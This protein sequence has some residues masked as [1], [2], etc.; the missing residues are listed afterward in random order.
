[1]AAIVISSTSFLAIVAG[2][3]AHPHWTYAGEEGP[4]H[5]GEFDPSCAVCSE[6]EGQ[7]PINLTGVIEAN[8]VRWLVLETPGIITAEQAE[9]F[10]TIFELNAR[11]VQPLNERDL[12]R[13]TTG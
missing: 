5:P 3:A 9:A 12:F 2:Q 4:D 7:S 1:M 8:G 13:D 6:G 11:P 10:A